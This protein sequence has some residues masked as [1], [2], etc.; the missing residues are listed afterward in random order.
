MDRWCPA[1]TW[2]MVCLKWEF[3]SL[4]KCRPCSWFRR[5][6]WSADLEDSWQA[7]QWRT[8]FSVAVS[9]AGYQYELRNFPFHPDDARM[10]A[11]PPV[12]EW[13]SGALWGTMRAV[14][15]LQ[16]SRRSAFFHSFVWMAWRSLVY[17]GSSRMACKMS[18]MLMPSAMR[19][20]W[21]EWTL[22]PLSST[23]GDT[24]GSLERQSAILLPEPRCT[25]KRRESVTGG[26]TSEWIWRV[27]FDWYVE[28]ASLMACNHID[29]QKISVQAPIRQL[30]FR[31]HWRRSY[32]QLV[33]ECDLSRPS[34]GAIMVTMV[35]TDWGAPITI[36]TGLAASLVAP[37]LRC[38]SA[39]AVSAGD[40]DVVEVLKSYVIFAQWA[41]LDSKISSPRCSIYVT[42][43]FSKLTISFVSKNRY[44]IL[45]HV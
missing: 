23:A 19:Q 40:C 33:W 44:E 1:L 24:E 25:E 20:I 16:K 45:L 27:F 38:W 14:R 4:L 43:S 9:I 35:R 34:P 39:S 11:M 42:S 32:V 21:T 36:A 29:A 8:W 2:S 6:S 7:M 5:V 12:E 15:T 17:V 18:I 26:P 13:G 28:E 3:P 22:M 10:A 30:K 31:S 41:L 37:I